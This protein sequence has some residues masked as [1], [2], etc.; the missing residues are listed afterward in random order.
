MR[1]RLF[2]CIILSIAF[3]SSYAQLNIEQRDSALQLK[4]GVPFPDFK[5]IDT[6]GKTFSGQDLK[7]KITVIN[8][9]FESCSPCIKELDALKKFFLTFKDNSDFQ[10]LSF[11]TDSLETA[12][13]SI[14]KLDIPFDV[15][16][17]TG[18][19][20]ERLFC[21]GFPTNIII[22]QYGK[23]AYIKAGIYP[24]DSHIRQ[25]ELLTAF[26]LMEKNWRS[27]YVYTVSASIL[28]DSIKTEKP[29]TIQD[30][31]RMNI[32][33]KDDIDHKPIVG[34]K[35][36]DFKATTLQGKN[37]SQEQLNGKVTMIDIWEQGCAPCFA[38]FE[39]FNKLYLDYKDNPVFQLFTFTHGTV[40]DV[41]EI[42]KEHK[43]L[44]DV[45]C[46]D[47]KEC[48]RL[49]YNSGFPT[50]II[51]DKSGIISFYD[52]KGSTDKE[53]VAKYFEELKNKI[54]NLLK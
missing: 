48:Y 53:K 41:K 16:P 36:M 9:W 39:F 40:D 22:D 50:I 49:N 34:R 12:K 33:K 28:P 43:L 8:F 51:I 14:E 35:Y 25:M 27:P 42:V 32:L 10:F 30:L 2:C 15:Y 44:Y 52:N 20:C 29:I 3:L 54:N 13:T 7:G 19:E 21:A 1:K 38:E 5:L 17:T 47:R 11:T 31:Y 23:V 6:K 45:A 26:L 18:K 4:I 37:I 46:M 24:S